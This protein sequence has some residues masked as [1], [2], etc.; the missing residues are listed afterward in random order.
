MTPAQAADFYE[1]AFRELQVLERDLLERGPWSAARQRIGDL[2]KEAGSLADALGPPARSGDERFKDAL[3]RVELVQSY[4]G[5]VAP[6]LDGPPPEPM[7]LEPS[8][9]VL[10]RLGK[11]LR[12]DDET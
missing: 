10:G 5:R 12:R 4:L 11:L 7:E 2:S 8:P 9:G 6:L 1:M 3:N